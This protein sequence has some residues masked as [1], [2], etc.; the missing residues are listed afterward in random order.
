LCLIGPDAEVS[1]AMIRSPIFN[2]G[3]IDEEGATFLRLT[4]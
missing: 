3:N 4:I 1:V 2:D